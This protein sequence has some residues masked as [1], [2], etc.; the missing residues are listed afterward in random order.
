[1]KKIVLFICALFLFCSCSNQNQAEQVVE[2]YM[3]TMSKG[4]TVQA[5]KMLKN[6][7]EEISLDE[8]ANEAGYTGRSRH[9]L[10]R[11]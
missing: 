8:M 3:E 6:A 1:M 4:K 11:I 9:I 10:N 7:K 5:N 2:S